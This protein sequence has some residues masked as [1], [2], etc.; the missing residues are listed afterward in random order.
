MYPVE[1]HHNL[2]L[3]IMAQ[4]SKCNHLLEIWKI[5]VNKI[6]FQSNDIH[7]CSI[8]VLELSIFKML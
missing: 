1:L 7:V 5:N 4:K 8:S 2:L 3:K 6:F